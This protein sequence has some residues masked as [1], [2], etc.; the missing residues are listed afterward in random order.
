MAPS[1]LAMAG[2]RRLALLR[3]AVPPPCVVRGTAASLVPVCHPPARC[4][5]RAHAWARVCWGA[6][7]PRRVVAG[8][9]RRRAGGGQGME[10]AMAAGGARRAAAAAH[11]A[12][13]PAPL[14]PALYVVATPL[15]NVEDVTLRALRVLRGATV[16]AA[17]DTRTTGKLL[18]ILEIPAEGRLRA[19]HAHNER[20]GSHIDALLA[21]VRGGG[22]VAL[23]SD[24]GTPLVSD[25]GAAL[26]AAAAADGLAVVPV[27]GPCAATAALSA[28]GIW[29][30]DG[31]SRGT[32]GA[33]ARGFTFLGFLPDAKAR[34]ADVLRFAARAPG[35][36]V[37]YAPPHDLLGTLDELAEACGASRNVCVAREITKLHEELWRGTLAGAREEFARRHAEGLRSARGELTLVLEGFGGDDGQGDGDGGDSA[38]SL[39]DDCLG[40][41]M[42][43]SEAAREVAALTGQRKRDVYAL[44]LERAEARD[45]G[46]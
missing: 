2:W 39:L 15:G 34:R 38:A 42:R 31:S 41:G 9:K 19:H 12:S 21:V 36:V 20:D 7:T 43:P 5:R 35:A 25:P 3:V 28:A 18:R 4:E 27:P 13:A 17:E 1:R 44:A 22:S 45:A 46:S 40:R 26:V 30:S 11:S 29:Q 24:A 37:L 14:A 10:G 33:L 23:V 32:A 6:P 8:A 16:I